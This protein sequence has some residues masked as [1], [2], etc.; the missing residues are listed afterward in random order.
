MPVLGPVPIRMMLGT[1]FF[2]KGFG[3]KMVHPLIALLLGTGNQTANVACAILER[4]F[5]DLNMKLWD[6]DP[7][8]LLPNLPTMVTFPKLGQF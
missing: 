7:D 6:Y 3:D 5:D 2:N 1:S 4:L 8:I